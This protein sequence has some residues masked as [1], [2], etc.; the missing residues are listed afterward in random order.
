MKH[1]KHIKQFES[2]NESNNPMKDKLDDILL[3]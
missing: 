3:F 1:M 2:F